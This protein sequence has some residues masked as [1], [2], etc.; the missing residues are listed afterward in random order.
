MY[1]RV[2]RVC[3][4]YR[5]R[6]GGVSSAAH[7]RA[8]PSGAAPGGTSVRKQTPANA[9]AAQMGARKYMR[10]ATDKSGVARE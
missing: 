10:G 8:A 7:V 6:R 4:H 2:Y 1:A 9:L 5:P 3:V